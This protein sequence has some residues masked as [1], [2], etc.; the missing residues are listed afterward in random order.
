MSAAYTAA[1]IVVSRS[2]AMAVSEICI[3][4]KVGVFVPYPFAAEDHQTFNAMQ[5]V[6]KGAALMVKDSEVN[7]KLMGTL[8]ALIQDESKMDSMKLNIK[9]FELLNADNIIAEQIIEYIQKV[10]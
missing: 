10:K 6:N 8:L 7:E 4:G 2:G 1:D 9:Q 3:T 5:L